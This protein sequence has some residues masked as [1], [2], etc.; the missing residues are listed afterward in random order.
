[1]GSLTE[2]FDYLQRKKAGLSVKNQPYAFIDV[3]KLEK[4]KS[5]PVKW[6]K[7]PRPEHL[8]RK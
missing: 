3:S 6:E 2:Y 5:I 4:K 1:M 8:P 7:L